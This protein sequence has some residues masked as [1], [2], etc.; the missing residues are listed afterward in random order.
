MLSETL[1]GHSASLTI[2][3]LSQLPNAFMVIP[4]VSSDGVEKSKFLTIGGHNGEVQ[5][6]FSMFGNML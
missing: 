1:T 4:H 5:H 6:E 3:R 2:K